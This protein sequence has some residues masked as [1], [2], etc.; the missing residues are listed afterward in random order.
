[1]KF[2]GMQRLTLLDYPGKTACTVFTEGCNLRCPFCHNAELV[3]PERM[4]DTSLSVDELMA[5]LRKRAGLLDGVCVSGGEPLLYYRDLRDL[6]PAIRELGYAV[7]LDTNGTNPYALAELLH[8]RLIDYVAMDIKNALPYYGETV[9]IPKFDTAP[10]WESI[11]ILMNDAVDYEFR[12]TVVREFHTVER[13]RELARSIT[14]AKRYFLQFFRDSGELIKD[15]L[16]AVNKEEMEQ[17]RIAANEFCP[18]E[19]RG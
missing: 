10:I 5:F 15:G 11:K 1:M 19:L 8:G 17:M 13:I 9:G 3:L 18:T 16:N 2:A 6:I 12:T 4:N 7:K 14:G